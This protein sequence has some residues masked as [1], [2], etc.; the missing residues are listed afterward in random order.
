MTTRRPLV[1][2]S[3]QVQELP[4]GDLLYGIGS[5]PFF[6]ADGTLSKILLSAAGALP[7]FKADGSSSDIGLVA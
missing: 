1:N 6:K 3:G 7:F 4:T 2:V 5:F